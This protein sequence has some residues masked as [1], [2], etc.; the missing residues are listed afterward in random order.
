MRTPLT[1]LVFGLAL[2]ASASVQAQECVEL[3]QV[4]TREI[5]RSIGAEQT[6]I[7]QKSN[8]C[9]ALYHE[10]TNNQQAQIQ[11]DYATF[12]GNASGS[13]QDYERHQESRCDHHFGS[14]WHDKLTL[15]ES[16]TISAL[17][18]D[19]VRDCLHGGFRLTALRTVGNVLTATFSFGGVGNVKLTSV[20]VNPSPLTVLSTTTTPPKLWA[21]SSK[22]IRALQ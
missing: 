5:S 17:G 21:L 1:G 6:D 19:V 7:Q 8:I 12:N 16:Q 14:Y 13:T 2:T 4:I 18:A 11:A 9:S 20:G 22:P 15:Q 10:A 3:A